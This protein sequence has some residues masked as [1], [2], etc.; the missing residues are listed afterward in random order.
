MLTLTP[1]ARAIAAFVL[2]VLL[3]FGTLDRLAYA[4]VS[5]FGN[6][7]STRT[8]TYA[9]LVVMIAIGTMILLLARTATT[10]TDGWAQATAQAATLLAAVGIGI[11][12][13]SLV[14][15]VLHDNMSMYYPYISG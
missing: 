6:G 3:V 4:V 9:I 14:A 11:V 12:V 5:L 15:S 7:M 1:Q 8:H 2:A 10:T 13:I